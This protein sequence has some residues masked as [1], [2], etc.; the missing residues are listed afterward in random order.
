M[1]KIFHPSGTLS[2]SEKAILDAALD[3][4]VRDFDRLGGFRGVAPDAPHEA[5]SEKGGWL[6]SE[7]V[8]R[9]KIDDEISLI[10]P[11]KRVLELLASRDVVA[12]YQS[13]YQRAVASI[14]YKQGRTLGEI[15]QS[16]RLCVCIA[17]LNAAGAKIEQV[18]RGTF[19]DAIRNA[20]LANP[21]AALAS[22]VLA[23][24]TKATMQE[25]RE[26][27]ATMQSLM[28]SVAMR[29]EIESITPEM[30]DK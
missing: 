25:R 16:A 14:Q 26:F 8:R 6:A 19:P 2:K 7:I 27:E 18:A 29:R 1:N 30:E 17:Y 3:A 12:G 20:G 10:E 5:C 15:K 22:F 21:L 23:Y 11:P 24:E 9:A 4:F 13:L 28:R